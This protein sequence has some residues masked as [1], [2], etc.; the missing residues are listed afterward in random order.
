ML[1]CRWFCGYKGADR[2][3][4]KCVRDECQLVILVARLDRQ[5][6]AFKDF[7]VA[8]PIGHGRSA[9][10]FGKMLNFAR[11]SMKGT[12]ACVVVRLRMIGAISRL[13]P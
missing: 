12:S 8:P 5:N 1:A 10:D 4:I 7:F 2:W 6:N 9:E 13:H 3:R 11:T